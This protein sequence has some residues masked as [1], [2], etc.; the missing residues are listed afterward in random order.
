MLTLQ[1]S[2]FD[3]RNSGDVIFAFN[4]N[5]DMACSGLLDNL[6]VFTQRLFSSISLVCVLFYNSWQ[7]ALIAVVVLGFAFLPGC[8]IR[9]RINDVMGKTLVADASVITAI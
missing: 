7:L 9:K 6:K 8:R 2:F 1:T 4:N 3:Q 5:A